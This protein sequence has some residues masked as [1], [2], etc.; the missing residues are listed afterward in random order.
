VQGSTLGHSK[1]PLDLLLELLKHC[2]V[3]STAF[4]MV[5]P[6]FG[7]LLAFED[8]VAEAGSIAASFRSHAQSMLADS[9]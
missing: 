1:Q 9:D 2:S 3:R 8:L 6:E 7:A 5:S 4:L